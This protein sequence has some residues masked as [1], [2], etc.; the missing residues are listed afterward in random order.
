M[1]FVCNEIRVGMWV[2]SPL[3]T[4]LAPRK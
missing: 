2:H 1:D 3:S 4:T